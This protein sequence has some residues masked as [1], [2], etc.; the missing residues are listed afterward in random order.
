MAIIVPSSNPRTLGD[1]KARI[2]DELA[3]ADLSSQITLAISDA[4]DESCT[5]RFWFMEVRNL[6]IAVTAGT[7]TYASDPVSQLLEI[8]RLKL[9][10]GQRAYTLPPMSDDELDMLNDGTAPTG[11]PYSYSR[12]TG[13][14][15]FY[16]I[17]VADYSVY[18]DGVTRGAPLLVDTDASIW[19]TNGEKYVRA[20]AKRNLYAELLRN[21]EQAQV[22]DGLAQRYR[23]ELEMQTHTRMATGEM[24][25]YA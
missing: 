9:F 21:P 2:A 13:Q 7:Q 5:H 20:L 24:V 17:P 11:Q 16:P 6:L 8:D 23:N 19:T 14:I 10:V 3:R 12:Y 22:C 18:I 1:L 15:S 4:I 25:A